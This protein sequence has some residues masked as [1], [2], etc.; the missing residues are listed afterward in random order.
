[1]KIK[2]NLK[3]LNSEFA[4]YEEGAR[5]IELNEKDLKFIITDYFNLKVSHIH[6]HAQLTDW[7]L[8]N[9]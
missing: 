4:L 2:F 1:M 7:E 8:I 3:Y 5:E 6:P 9:E